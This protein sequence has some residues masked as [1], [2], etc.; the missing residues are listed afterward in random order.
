MRSPISARLSV[1]NGVEVG[2]ACS[3]LSLKLGAVVTHLEERRG[4]SF[5]QRRLAL[6]TSPVTVDVG[7]SQRGLHAYTRCQLL[8]LFVYDNDLPTGQ[9]AADVGLNAT[10]SP[11]DSSA[12]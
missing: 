5:G 9:Q 2:G 7:A 12:L 1:G 3:S 11:P 4:R 8:F 10:A 6:L